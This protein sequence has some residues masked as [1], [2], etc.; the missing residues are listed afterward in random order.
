MSDTTTPEA[1]LAAAEVAAPI[2]PLYDC[3]KQVRAA[4]IRAICFGADGPFLTREDGGY[5]ITIDNDYLVKHNPKPGGYFVLYEDGYQSFSPAGAFEAG[6]TL[7][8]ES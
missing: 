5:D 4:K 2:L 1:A 3:H 7:A 6:Y 8:Q